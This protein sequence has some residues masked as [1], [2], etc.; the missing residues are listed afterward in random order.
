M[1]C[2]SGS[3]SRRKRDGN[4]IRKEA[5]VAYFEVLSSGIKGKV[6]PVLSSMKAYWGSEG[7]APSIL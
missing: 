5:I 6:V 2:S 1:D 3:S 4:I 7:I